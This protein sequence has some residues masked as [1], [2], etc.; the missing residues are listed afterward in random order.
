MLF[1]A[2]SNTFTS[3]IDTIFSQNKQYQYIYV[4]VGSKYNERDIIF[5]TSTIP[6]SNYKPTNALYQMVPYFLQNKPLDTNVLIIIIDIFRDI[7][8]IDKNTSMVLSAMTKNID[9][10]MVS[11]D[12]C[13]EPFIDL[14][15]L[16]MT[17]VQKQN[18]LVTR[19]MI[20]NYVKFMNIPNNNESNAE[21]TVVKSITSVLNQDQFVPYKD[22]FYQWYGY[23]YHL[24][25]YIYK[26]SMSVTDLY[27]NNTITDLHS[28]MQR[29]SHSPH[30]YFDYNLKI[31]RILEHSYDVTSSN[32]V[33]PDVISIPMSRLVRCKR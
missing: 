28:L 2:N 16:L 25:D 30:I 7:V 14:C 5:R 27:F 29:W 13:S 10:C 15:I 12:C 11:M 21:K 3:I 9:M 6:L 26:H 33:D 20:C 24:Y 1:N 18:I 8:T 31:K 22:C 32:D 4:S 17:H 23:K 19:F